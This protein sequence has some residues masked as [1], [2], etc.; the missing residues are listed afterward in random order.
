VRIARTDRF[1]LAGTRVRERAG[2]L[3]SLS[4]PTA[5]NA[6]FTDSTVFATS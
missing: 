3:D 6:R 2:Y 1:L 4:I 5:D